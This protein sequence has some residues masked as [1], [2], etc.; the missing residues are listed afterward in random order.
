MWAKVLLCAALMTGAA[1]CN[2]VTYQ[3]PGTMPSGQTVS[4]KGWFFLWGLVGEKE[5]WANKMCPGGVAQI[6]SKESFLDLLIGG[7]TG[8]LVAPRSYDIECGAGK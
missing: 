4:E 2:K 7:I 3:N 5:I 1:A 8:G 6:Q